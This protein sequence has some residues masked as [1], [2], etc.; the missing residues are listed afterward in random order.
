[1]YASK[2]PDVFIDNEIWKIEEPEYSHTK[3]EIVSDNNFHWLT[4][5]INNYYT[6]SH[7]VDKPEN[8]RHIIILS[9]YIDIEILC[10]SYTVNTPN[11]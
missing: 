10:S 7:P 6:R 2:V 11:E 8:I 9:D 3:M 5:T 1:M 4:E